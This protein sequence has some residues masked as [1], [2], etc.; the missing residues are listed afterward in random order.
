MKGSAPKADKK[1]ESF[2]SKTHKNQYEVLDRESYRDKVDKV[3]REIR[4]RDQVKIFLFSYKT[5]FLAYMF[6]VYFLPLFMSVIIGY[7]AS[8][9]GQ[10]F[11]DDTGLKNFYVYAIQGYYFYIGILNLNYLLEVFNA[12]FS[13]NIAYDDIFSQLFLWV[14]DQFT[15]ALLA[16]VY[17]F[18]F[19]FFLS[20]IASNV[21][22]G[23]L[24]KDTYYLYGMSLFERRANKLQ[25]LYELSQ[26]TSA[27]EKRLRKIQKQKSEK[28]SMIIKKLKAFENNITMFVR[29]A[30]YPYKV[31][32]LNIDSIG[33]NRIAGIA[34]KRWQ[35]HV[36][37]NTT[38]ES[39]IECIEFII[40]WGMNKHQQ[41]LVAQIDFQFVCEKKGEKGI[42]KVFFN[43]PTHIFKCEKYLQQNMFKLLAFMTAVKN[44]P[45]APVYRFLET[46]NIKFD[47]RTKLT[48]LATRKITDFMIERKEKK[49]PYRVLPFSAKIIFPTFKEEKNYQ[50]AEQVFMQLQ[51]ENRGYLARL[52]GLI[53]QIED[54]DEDGVITFQEHYKE[55]KSIINKTFLEFSNI[56]FK[57]IKG[58]DLYF[59]HK[60]SF[61]EQVANILDIRWFSETDDKILDNFSSGNALTI[62]VVFSN[63]VID[64]FLYLLNEMNKGVFGD[65]YVIKP[66]YQK[67]LE[68]QQVE[69]LLR[70]IT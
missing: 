59:K 45:L 17:L 64:D 31:M 41:E 32:F 20:F 4:R 10:M 24:L 22:L 54:N 53:S 11:L 35:K 1:K 7:F 18:I 13:I 30:Y 40:K 57:D 46:K 69:P 27:G 47:D 34:N 37:K 70:A 28:T 25:E 15:A 8:E 6:F 60:S 26:D 21:I 66:Y 42:E 67:L 33:A 12:L 51:K 56:Y 61:E 52:E 63:I 48:I 65:F 58:F 62:I 50:Q 2:D 44:M 68:E 19:V 43:D 23:S 39:E 36:K 14:D 55:Y 3:H 5:A 9:D 16:Q 38:L 49:T 29:K